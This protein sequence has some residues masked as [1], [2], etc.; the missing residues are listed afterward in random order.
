MTVFADEFKCHISRPFMLSL[1]ASLG[2]RLKTILAFQS[3][4]DLADCPRT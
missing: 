2:W 4:Q 1:G 3:L